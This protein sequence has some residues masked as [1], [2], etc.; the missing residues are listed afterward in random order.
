MLYFKKGNDGFYRRVSAYCYRNDD[1]EIGERFV[2]I[3]EPIDI[4][5]EHDYVTKKT[6]ELY[7]RYLFHSGSTETEP[8]LGDLIVS[9]LEDTVTLFNET[10]KEEVVGVYSTYSEYESFARAFC[11]FMAPNGRVD[12]EVISSLTDELRM[13]EK[14]RCLG[15]ADKTDNNS[16]HYFKLESYVNGEWK[17]FCSSIINCENE[18]DKRALNGVRC[19]TKRNFSRGL[20][21]DRKAKY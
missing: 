13:A 21:L 6:S 20:K 17:D 15:L 2:T 1:C 7:A 14:L 10:K 4:L 19:V 18:E 16:R 12:E 9:R 11:I 8:I 3:R 5:G